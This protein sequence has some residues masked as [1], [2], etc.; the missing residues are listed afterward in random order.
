MIR[1]PNI[2]ALFIKQ[3]K[4]TLKNM[5]VLILFLVY[6][7]V[8]L[9]M[10]QAMPKQDGTADLFLSIYACMHCVFTPIIAAA[11]ALA[12]EKQSNTLRVLVLSN[13]TLREYFLSTGSFILLADLITG[14][15]FLLSA[16]RNVTES[17]LFL[18]FLGIGCLI[19]IVLGLCVGLYAK[20]SAA[21]SGLAVPIGMVFAFVPMLASFNKNIENVSRFTYGQQISYLLAGKQISVTGIIILLVNAAVLIALSAF[22]YKRTLTEEG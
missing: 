16:N 12:E 17:L 14:S 22:L 9:V 19:S 21:A 5:P 1:I 20:N 2:T 13:V 18:L 6:P 4:N 7:C 8:S 3:L 15:T 10:T 11:F